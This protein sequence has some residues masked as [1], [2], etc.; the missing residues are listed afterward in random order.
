MAPVGS[1]PDGMDLYLFKEGMEPKWEDATC[2]PGGEWRYQV[3]C[4]RLS[5]WSLRCSGLVD[6]FAGKGVGGAE[7][8]SFLDRASFP[9]PGGEEEPPGRLVRQRYVA[10]CPACLHRRAVQ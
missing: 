1:L 3:S 6:R 5:L 8:G 10:E 7:V 4:L 2:L 9:C